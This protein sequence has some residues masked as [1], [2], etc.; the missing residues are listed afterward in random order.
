MIARSLLAAALLLPAAAAHAQG[1]GGHVIGSLD[2]ATIYKQNCQ[3]CH[4]PDAKGSHVV[5]TVPALAANPKLADEGYPIGMVLQGRGAMPWFN[6]ALSPA[7]I[8]SVVTYVRTHFGNHYPKPVTADEVAK[9]APPVPH[10][11]H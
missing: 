6:G 10:E 2:G 7:Q 8:A 9:M 1:P 5:I 4:Q 3:A 11:S